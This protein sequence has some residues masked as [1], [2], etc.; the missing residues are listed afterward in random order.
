MSVGCAGRI[1]NPRRSSS[2]L[3]TPATCY[4]SDHERGAVPTLCVVPGVSHLPDPHEP[5]HPVHLLL[6]A[7]GGLLYALSHV[8]ANSDTTYADYLARPGWVG[9]LISTTE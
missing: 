9:P 3:D 8:P 7:P 1:P 2:I 6:D 5:D 4:S